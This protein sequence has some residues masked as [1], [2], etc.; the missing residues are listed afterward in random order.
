MQ[1]TEQLYKN[2][3]MESGDMLDVQRGKSR[4][5]ES[6]CGDHHGDGGRTLKSRSRSPRDEILPHWASSLFPFIL[7]QLWVLCL[8][9]HI[10]GDLC[11]GPRKAVHQGEQSLEVIFA[12]LL[13]IIFKPLVL[14]RE[15]ITVQIYNTLPQVQ[16]QV[17]DLVSWTGPRPGLHIF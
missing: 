13:Q 8:A 5:P 16:K 11:E 2:D 7:E 1:R 12:A 15:C 10:A 3:H 6:G 4:F 17:Q 9:A 14:G